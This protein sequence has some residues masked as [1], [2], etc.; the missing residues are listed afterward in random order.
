MK[1]KKRYVE[2]FVGITS[3][4]YKELGDRHRKALEIFFEHRFDRILDTGCGDGKFTVLIGKACKAKEVYGADISEKGVEM[5]RKKGIKAFRVDVDG[6]SLPFE[7]NYFDAIYAGAII[8]HLFDPDHFLDEVYRVLKPNGILVL[9]T[10]N[11]A[12]LYNRIALLLGYL[13][14]DMQVSLRYSVGHLLEI[15]QT[16]KGV[17]RASDHIRFFTVKSLIA[18]LK[19]HGF[20]ITKIYGS[21]DLISIKNPLTCFILKLMDNLINKIPSLSRVIIIVCNKKILSVKN[22]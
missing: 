12:S 1:A 20:L 18:L 4:E 9:D 2:K 21:S 15:Y 17:V 13:P 14:F 3:E 16:S 22:I 6:E 8:E 11:L 19:R 7:N 10:P 5:A